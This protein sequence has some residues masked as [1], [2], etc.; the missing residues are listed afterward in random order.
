MSKKTSIIAITLLIATAVVLGF[1]LV[2][3]GD[4]PVIGVIMSDKMV[5]S[6]KDFE[7]VNLSEGSGVYIILKK[8]YN[9]FNEKFMT[10]I[11]S[12]KDLYANIYFVECPKGS[13]YT[14]RWVTEGKTVKEE[15]KELVTEQKGVASFVFDGNKVISGNYSLELYNEGKKIF[16]YKFPIH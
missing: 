14:A 4:G 16:E 13:K 5:G 9:K 7:T 1:V 10:D 2:N 12:G 3:K 6:V 15:I 8:E 11:P